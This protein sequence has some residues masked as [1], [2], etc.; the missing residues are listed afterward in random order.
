MALGPH[1]A[2]RR[3]KWT[4]VNKEPFRVNSPHGSVKRHCKQR[5]GN[6]KRGVLRTIWTKVTCCTFHR[7]RTFQPLDTL[8]VSSYSGRRRIFRQSHSEHF[9]RGNHVGCD[10]RH[11]RVAC[12]RYLHAR[13]APCL[14][15]AVGIGLL[16]AAGTFFRHEHASLP[17]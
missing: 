12:F 1:G 7:V 5:I 9:S 2:R 11:W 15:L 3:M 4:K 17:V 8:R 10:K 13:P 6:S 14:R 16:E